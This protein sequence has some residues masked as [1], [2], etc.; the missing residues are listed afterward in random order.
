MRGSE[1]WVRGW[2]FRATQPLWSYLGLCFWHFMRSIHGVYSW[3]LF[4][5]S[6]GDNSLANIA[7]GVG[8]CVLTGAT[9]R[10]K[11]E[12]EKQ[13]IIAILARQY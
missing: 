2:M 5:G 1:G 11:K 7:I 6:M 12:M 4:M 3:G 8:G 10:L 9:G 13:A